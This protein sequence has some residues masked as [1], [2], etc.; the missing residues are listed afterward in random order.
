[1]F[2]VILAAQ[3]GPRGQYGSINPLSK[4]SVM[5]YSSFSYTK[6]LSNGCAGIRG[7]VAIVTGMSDK[8][9]LIRLRWN[10]YP[11]QMHT[12]EQGI[13]IHRVKSACEY[14][15]VC[16]ST[17]LGCDLI[18]KGT[19]PQSHIKHWRSLLVHL[20]YARRRLEILI[21]CQLSQHTN[22]RITAMTQVELCWK[23]EVLMGVSYLSL[24]CVCVGVRRI[25]TSS[26]LDFH[27]GE[28][29]DTSDMGVNHSF[30][31]LYHPWE[32]DIAL[33]P[34][35]PPLFRSRFISFSFI[36]NLLYCHHLWFFFCVN[37]S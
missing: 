28:N 4:T 19:C 18:S 35:T 13:H 17:H 2:I 23:V 34:P 16:V 21:C 7:T 3:N 9:S 30:F 14:L 8:N 33:L 22:T 37:A 26:R 29:N 11:I 25:Y 6:W 1:M 27:L 5:F 12:E 32:L 15:T 36:S 20:N 24:M 31:S 10:L